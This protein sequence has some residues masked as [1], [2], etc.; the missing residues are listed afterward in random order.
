MTERK[1]RKKNKVRGE[2]THGQGDTKNNRGS[3]SRGGT[4]KANGRKG[5]FS[6]LWI[7]R[8]P[9]IKLK[10]AKKG[11]EITVEQLNSILDK[12]V[13]KGKVTKTKEMYIVDSDC[14]Y[15][16]VLSQGNINKKVHL[17]INASTKAIDKIKKAGGKFDFAKKGYEK[18]VEEENEE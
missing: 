9:R 12:L 18:D 2:R 4:G 1:R 10:A 5:K 17:K 14:G 8:G 3:G 15:A 16:K 6:S 13:E 11:K 7:N